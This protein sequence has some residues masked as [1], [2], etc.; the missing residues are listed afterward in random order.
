MESPRKVSKVEGAKV[1]VEQDPEISTTELCAVEVAFELSEENKKL[2]QKVEQL[3]AILLGSP[4]KQSC[5]TSTLARIPLPVRKR[6]LS[7]PV[8][9]SPPSVVDADSEEDTP[10]RPTVPACSLTR[11]PRCSTTPRIDCGTTTGCTTTPR[12]S[13]ATSRPPRCSLTP[14][15]E[16][17]EFEN[18][19][20]EYIGSFPLETSPFETSADL[21]SDSD[22]RNERN[23][24]DVIQSS[25]DTM[26]EQMEDLMEADD[27]EESTPRPRDLQ[28]GVAN[29]VIS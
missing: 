25:V 26:W 10:S 9:P 11:P 7:A 1:Q 19:T 8:F 18:V 16:C 17:D 21:R 22:G 2:K 12:V 20:D 14:Q 23:S 29:C 28:C 5:E 4:A 6:R 3:Q 27:Q 13:I 15:I 24:T